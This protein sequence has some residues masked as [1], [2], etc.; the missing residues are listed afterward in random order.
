MR[1]SETRRAFERMADRGQIKEDH[2]DLLTH[3]AIYEAAGNAFGR[4]YYQ[5]TWNKAEDEVQARRAATEGAQADTDNII[6]A[7]ERKAKDVGQL[8]ARMAREAIHTTLDLPAVLGRARD[9]VIRPAE[10]PVNL[11]S[12]LLNGAFKRTMQNFREMP[13]LQ[14]DVDTLGLFLQPE[15]TN[16]RYEGFSWSED[17]YA[18]SKYSRA[19][20]WTWEAKVNDDLQSFLDESAALGYA[21][22]MNRLKVLF[23]AIVAG[24]ARTTLTGT[25]AGAG[26]PTIANVDAARAALAS[27]TPPRRLGG[28]SIPV[29]WEGLA[30]A[31]RDNQFVPASTPAELNPVYSAFTV[32]VEE[33][34]ADVLAAAPSGNALDWLAHDSNIASWLEFATLRGFEGGP[35]IVFKLPDTRESGYGSFD[36]MTD[37]MKV[38]D[39]VGAKVIDGTRVL[40]VAGA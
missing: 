21:A 38:V 8:N 31:T 40:R 27:S 3:A 39:V 20:G 19:I 32:N 14:K 24:T 11:E 10:E 29:P 25:G 2:V 22:R 4:A 1:L 26:G 16:V 13:S 36:N 7:W 34:L 17:K 28:I 6:M 18:V 5:E 15:G 12:A 35:S 23:L 9:L 33:Y 37:A 30:N